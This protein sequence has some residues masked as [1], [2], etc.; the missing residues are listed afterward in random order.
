MK[1]FGNGYEKARSP[2]AA[3]GSFKTICQHL[4]QLINLSFTECG[5]IDEGIQILTDARD[6]SS[7]AQGD[8]V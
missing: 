4:Q 6:A 7:D 8:A 5:G 1:L 2:E 3:H